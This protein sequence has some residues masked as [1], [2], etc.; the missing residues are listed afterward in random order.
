MGDDV[1]EGGFEEGADEGLENIFLISILGFT[2][3]AAADRTDETAVY[4]EAVGGTTDA[5]ED[6]NGFPLT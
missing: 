3:G 5:L 6:T 2:G 1:S 4:V